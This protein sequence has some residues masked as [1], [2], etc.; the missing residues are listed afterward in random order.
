MDRVAG[1]SVRHA[2]D[3]R[4]EPG[5]RADFEYRDLGIRGAT[6]GR[7]GAHVIRAVPGKPVLPVRH[8]HEVDFQIVYVLQG[9][10]TF[11]Y[12]GIG[13]VKLVA[14]SCVHQP[15]GLPHVEVGHSDDLEMLEVVA[16]ADFRTLNE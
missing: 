5:L 8:H 9:W 1:F 3:A 14:G 12:D 15:S 2:A 6:G 10:I 4:F 7:V 13:E 11:R 16:P